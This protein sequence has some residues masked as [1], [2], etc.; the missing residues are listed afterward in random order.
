[1]PLFAW[2]LAAVGPML[3]QGAISLGVATVTYIGFDTAVGGLLDM[4]RANW[5]GMP[6]TAA[7]FAA[8]AG[9]N[10]FVG[11]IAGAITTKITLIAT[12]K[13]KLK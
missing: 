6:A 4:A 10:K 7:A 5:S 11:I 3:V 12:K 1:M 13:F 8:M 2:F 9:F